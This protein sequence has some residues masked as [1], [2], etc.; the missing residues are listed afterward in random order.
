MADSIVPNLSGETTMARNT[1]LVVEDDRLIL[2]MLAEGLRNA[3][4]HVLGADS[5]EDA[6]RLL[7]QAH[8]H[9]YPDIALLD[10]RLPGMSGIDLAQWLKNTMDIPFLFLSA[11]SDLEAVNKAV[12]FGALGYLVKPLDMPQILPS[13]STAL[14]RSREMRQLQQTEINLSAALKTSRNLS[15]AIGLCMERF[16]AGADET[17]DALRAYCRDN[18]CKMVDVVAQLV[19]RHQEIDLTPYLHASGKPD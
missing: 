11:Y 4:Y 7:A 5:G 6:M 18:R 15:V 8:P 3:G 16:G 13:I 2:H 19:E 10:M 9:P 1:I 17:F 14:Q 12:E